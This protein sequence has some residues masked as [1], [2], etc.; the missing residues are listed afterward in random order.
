RR[1][2]TRSYGDWSSDVCSSDLAVLETPVCRREDFLFGRRG[3]V[4][5]PRADGTRGEDQAPPGTR[6]R[7]DG[8]FADRFAWP[9]VYPHK[10]TFKSEERRVGKE[11][12]AR[13]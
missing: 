6:G 4:V 9:A 11:G 5:H 3:H 8:G 1:R 12:R 10:R 7:I 13:W 2:H